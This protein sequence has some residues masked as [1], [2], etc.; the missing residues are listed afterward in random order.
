MSSLQ[1]AATLLGPLAGLLHSSLHAAACQSPWPSQIVWL[2]VTLPCI[3]SKLETPDVLSLSSVLWNLQGFA[4]GAMPGFLGSVS[5]SQR[6]LFGLNQKLSASAEVGQIDKTFKLSHHDPWVR[7]DPH[8]TSRTIS[9][10]NNRAVG[11]CVW[12]RL[13][14]Q[15]VHVSCSQNNGMCCLTGCTLVLKPAGC[16]CFSMAPPSATTA[17]AGRPAGT[18]S[19]AHDMCRQTCRHGDSLSAAGLK[20]PSPAHACALLVQATQ[21]TAGPR[22]SWAPRQRRES[23]RRGM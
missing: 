20:T 21:F 9:I 14:S 1:C 17:D 3:T 18:G 16:Q 4:E 23:S 19:T 10:Q 12:G 2:P 5:F 6:N 7:G 13:H 15:C 11:V 22:M 8:H